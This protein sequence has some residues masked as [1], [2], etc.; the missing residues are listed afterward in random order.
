[1]PWDCL[2]RLIGITQST[3]NHG[4]RN[5]N[6]RF[7]VHA[8]LSAP[9]ILAA[10]AAPSS[11]I[12][13]DNPSDPVA[14]AAGVHLHKLF[15]ATTRQKSPDSTVYF[16]G[17]RAWETSFAQVTASIP[18]NHQ[19]GEIER[20]RGK[21]PDPEKEFA[22]IDPALFASEREF[23]VHLNRALMAKPRGQRNI[24]VFIHGYNNS[25][26][27]ALMRT[28]QF[29]EDSG[30]QGVPV[31][32]SWASR[33]KPLEY[34]Y[35]MNSAL[36]ARNHLIRLFELMQKTR[37]ERFDVLAHSM[38]NLLLVE[39]IRQIEIANRFHAS[40]KL[41]TVVMAAPDI[42]VDLFADTL[43]RLDANARRFYV[44]VSKDDKALR[45]ARLIAG[46]I[47][48]AGDADARQLSQLGV[49]AIDLTNVHD[50]STL[51][52]DTFAD[53]PE[54][55]QMIGNRMRSDEHFGV[56][57]PNPVSDVLTTARIVVFGQ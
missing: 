9:V 36:L 23:V 44:L 54:V 34:V 32:F 51:H 2:E 29:V 42:D 41:G 48:R 3:R 49:I 27:G 50:P 21:I 38:G 37:A 56:I 18:P 25:L 15:I 26:N 45:Y 12:G 40:D 16:S 14:R 24:L 28:A 4:T 10:C 39:T 35:D 5:Y 43:M 57:P 13:V 6:R 55:V 19:V 53:S 33:G 11:V 22:L 52:H 1:M 47:D 46:G 7:V 8:A 31:L 30:F 20:P 17:E